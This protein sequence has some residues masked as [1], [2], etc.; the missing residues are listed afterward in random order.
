MVKF[1]AEEGK[2]RTGKRRCLPSSSCPLSDSG[3]EDGDAGD[4]GEADAATTGDWESS[5]HSSGGG[6]GSSDGGKESVT[7]TI[8]LDVL[9]CP[10]CYEIMDPPIFQCQN[11]HIT[12]SSCCAKMNR[13]HSCLLP[14][15]PTRC[16]ALEKVVESIKVPCPYAGNGCGE[17]VG[18]AQRDAHKAACSH[19]PCH[20]PI[21][22]C[23][24]T[25]SVPQLARHFRS[26]HAHCGSSLPYN[27]S[28]KLSLD[29][30]SPS[31]SSS[32]RTA[33]CSFFSTTAAR[34]WGTPSPW[35][36]L[37]PAP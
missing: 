22:G 34:R 37:G 10:I 36:A 8:D 1:S 20:C 9:E 5:E 28:L 13:C 31:T 6:N 15:G 18:Y 23:A 26:L 14:L 7:V 24:F 25:G 2:K 4:A 3:E 32:G 12:C 17:I 21:A 27:R 29:D 33:S 11:G 19:A 16:L 35:C 30:R